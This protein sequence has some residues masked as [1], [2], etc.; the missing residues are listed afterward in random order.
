MNMAWAT[1]TMP[2]NTASTA[3]ASSTQMCTTIERRRSSRSSSAPGSATASA[4]SSAVA[5]ISDTSRIAARPVSA[6]RRPR[7]DAP[8]GSA[9]S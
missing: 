5:N 3:M 7:H 4:P 1:P 2:A 9:R 6:P 8:A